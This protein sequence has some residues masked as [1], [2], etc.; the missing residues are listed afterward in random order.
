MLEN[1]SLN[2]LSA[3]CLILAALAY[4]KASWVTTNPLRRWIG[5]S[6]AVSNLIGAFAFIVRIE[7]LGWGML[8]VSLGLGTY[9][10]WLVKP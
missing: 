8:F 3:F 6:L 5:C 1:F 4:F 2:D 10:V 7:P 9:Y